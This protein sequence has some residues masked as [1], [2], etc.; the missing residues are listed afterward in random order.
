MPQHNFQVA[1]NPRVGQTTQYKRV[2]QE[3]SASA[4]NTLPKAT[5]KGR[6]GLAVTFV[7]DYQFVEKGS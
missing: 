2:Y 4:R 3:L 5:W 6:V 1:D 7:N